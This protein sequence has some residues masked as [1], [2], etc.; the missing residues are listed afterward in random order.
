LLG[1]LESIVRFGRDFARIHAEL[2]ITHAPEVVYSFSSTC[3]IVT[4]W[5][6]YSDNKA[7]T[8]DAQCAVFAFHVFFGGFFTTE[9]NVANVCQ[10][11]RSLH[12]SNVF[13]H[14]LKF[15][16]G[17]CQFAVAN[18]IPLSIEVFPARQITIFALSKDAAYLRW[19]ER[20]RKV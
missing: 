15:L 4:P 9:V 7:I 14:L 5:F 19:L 11:A 13:N 17:V 3:S 18:E 20:L 12:E 10:K 16:Q 8:K 2:S 6:R 1:V